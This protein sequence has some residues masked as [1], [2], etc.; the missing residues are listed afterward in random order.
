MPGFVDA[1]AAHLP[2]QWEEAGGVA[3]AD[4]SG[5]V[6]W[7]WA[8]ELGLHVGVARSGAFVLVPRRA[9]G[10][11]FFSASRS[12][13]TA[14]VDAVRWAQQYRRDSSAADA[15][16]AEPDADT[17]TVEPGGRG[18]TGCGP[19][20]AAVDAAVV[21]GCRARPSR[22]RCE[23]RDQLAAVRGQAGH[24]RA[25]EDGLARAR[26]RRDAAVRAAAEAGASLVELERA[27]G[28]PP[29]QLRRILGSS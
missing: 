3:G 28:L 6:R 26:E 24:V 9:A 5:R 16:A 21:V 14:A 13:A 1:V 23:A 29:P 10:R 20:V 11:L 17:E 18:P 2:A 4:T 15:R 12:P 25:A 19:E 22:R 8:A 27:S 7:F